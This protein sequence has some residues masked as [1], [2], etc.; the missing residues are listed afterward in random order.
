MFSGRI[1]AK[2]AIENTEEAQKVPKEQILEVKRRKIPVSGAV[3]SIRSLLLTQ[4]EYL[5]WAIGPRLGREKRLL[6]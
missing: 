6:G 2:S 5:A 4:S 3:A 1:K